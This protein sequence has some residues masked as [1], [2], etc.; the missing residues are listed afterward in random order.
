MGVIAGGVVERVLNV[1]MAVALLGTR[2]LN[3]LGHRGWALPNRCPHKTGDQ[4]RDWWHLRTSVG[5]KLSIL[6]SASVAAG[7]GNRSVCV[8]SISPRRRHNPGFAVRGRAIRVGRTW[9]YRRYRQY[10]NR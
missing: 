5:L 7:V 1:F 6:A 4:P 8:H 3:A 2:P 9:N 10:P